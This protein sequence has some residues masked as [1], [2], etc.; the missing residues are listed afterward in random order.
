MKRM[1][2][3]TSQTAIEEFLKQGVHSRVAK[4][5]VWPTGN[6]LVVD[7]EDVVRLNADGT[8][9]ELTDEDLDATDWA[10]NEH[11]FL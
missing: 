10:L 9:T 8:M 3:L 7:G 1:D 4:R 6:T 2:G 11:E 5:A